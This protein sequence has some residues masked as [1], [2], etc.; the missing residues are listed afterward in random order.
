MYAFTI[1]GGR[2]WSV[3]DAAKDLPLW[4]CCNYGL[5]AHVDIQADG[6]GTMTL[7]LIEGRRGQGPGLVTSDFGQHWIAR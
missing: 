1:D 2:I 7:H 4:Q 5:I 3:W 6:N